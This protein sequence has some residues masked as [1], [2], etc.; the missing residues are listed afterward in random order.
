MPVDSGDVPPFLLRFLDDKG[1]LKQMP[2]RQRFQREA[3]AYL[4]GKFHPGIT[5]SEGEVNELLMLWHTFRDWALL[6]RL[7]YDWG[8]LDRDP[9]GSRYWLSEA[10]SAPPVTPRQTT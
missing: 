1:R 8:Y 9:D 10:A 6:R 5:Y 7:L 4:A 2:A 3:I